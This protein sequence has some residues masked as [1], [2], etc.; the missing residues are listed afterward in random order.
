MQDIAKNLVIKD[1]C[2]VKDRREQP[3]NNKTTR[4][5]ISVIKSLNNYENKE[6]VRKIL[7]NFFFQEGKDYF[8]VNNKNKIIIG[9][10]SHGPKYDKN[11]NLIPYSF[12]GPKNLFPS[13]KKSFSQRAILKSS[14]ISKNNTQENISPKY[15]KHSITGDKKQQITS[16]NYYKIIDENL[17]QKFYENI[18]KRVNNEN[19]NKTDVPKLIKECLSAQQ[20]FLKKI[21]DNKKQ[22]DLFQNKLCKKCHKS[23]QDLLLIKS[24]DF[25]Y[26]NQEELTPIRSKKN[27]NKSSKYDF[28][29][30][31]NLW[32][33][34]LRNPIS[35]KGNY[36]FLGYQK[37]GSKIFSLFSTFNLKK[38]KNYFNNHKHCLSLENIKKF[39]VNQKRTT[40]YLNGI[41]S[42]KVN[43]KNLLEIELEKEIGFNG[44]KILFTPNDIDMFLYKERYKKDINNLEVK[45]ECFGQ[46]T[47][48]ENFNTNDFYDNK[49]YNPKYMKTIVSFNNSKV[50]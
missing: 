50:I 19:N 36:K 24:N 43:G 25:Q 1:V 17:L 22:E 2:N 5:T 49:N 45:K 6:N 10:S 33:N 8:N 21:D 12:V 23:K 7:R 26:K 13:V 31:A 37:S 29:Q 47:F 39:S 46:K 18:K 27:S 48:A 34:T 28:L 41:N 42:I 15:Q 4:N 40:K 30:K 11:S 38:S 32:N 3:N 16:H 20:L 44:K 9:K 35:K 14:K